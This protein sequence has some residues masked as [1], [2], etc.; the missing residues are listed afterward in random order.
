[1]SYRLFDFLGVRQGTME[2]LDQMW[3]YL[4]SSE[5]VLVGMSTNTRRVMR[6]VE[7]GDVQ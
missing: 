1:M 4:W 2:E 6:S 3:T 5:E 7:V